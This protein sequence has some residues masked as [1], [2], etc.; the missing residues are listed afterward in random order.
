MV[1]IQVQNNT[2]SIPLGKRLEN[3]ARVVEFDLSDFISEYGE[4]TA[5]LLAKRS[6]DSTAYPVNAVREGDK[7]LWT[8]LNSDTEYKGQG[9]CEL[10]WYVGE[11]LAKSVVY[12]TYVEPDI[13]EN[14]ETPPEPYESW[15]ENLIETVDEKLDTAQSYVEDSE[16]WAK[17]TRNGVAVGSSDETYH[18]NSKY[19]SE[20]SSAYAT[21][22]AASAQEAST[23]LANTIVIGQDGNFYINN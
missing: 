8:V 5:V 13:G 14:S 18:K 7:L 4:G 11:T 10:F 3:G 19:Y 20:Q 21:A 2:T 17:G 6:Q 9:K 12:G 15:I 16:A 23:I 22:A 1:T